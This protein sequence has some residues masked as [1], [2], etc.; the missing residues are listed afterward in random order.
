MTL[1][2]SLL[3][4][5]KVFTCP[6]P[7]SS[8]EGWR[9]TWDHFTIVLNVPKSS[10]WPSFGSRVI[11]YFTVLWVFL[12]FFNLY[13]YKYVYIHSWWHVNEF[14]AKETSSFAS[15]TACNLQRFQWMS[16]PVALLIH[17]LQVFTY[18][19]PGGSYSLHL[20]RPYHRSLLRILHLG[21]FL[22]KK[23]RRCFVNGNSKCFGSIALPFQ[24]K[25]RDHVP[26]QDL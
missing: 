6:P 3:L 14:E 24:K 22:Q 21:F 19:N 1:V 26:G 2:E 18:T 4:V 11:N 12:F 23:K 20:D 10:K 16:P 17:S 15:I 7:I 5:K 9:A 8:F 13:I 25:T